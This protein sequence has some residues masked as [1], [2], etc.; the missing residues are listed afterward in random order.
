[1]TKP[2]VL[3]LATFVCATSAAAQ[4]PTLSPAL[5]R[6]RV[7]REWQVKAK[8]MR[9]ILQPLMRKHG[10]DL[11]V[12]MSRENAPDPAI[13]LFGGN[14]ITGRYGHRNAF[15]LR[16][17]GD[18]QPLETHVI[19]THSGNHSPGFHRRPRSVVAPRPPDGVVV[20]HSPARSAL[21]PHTD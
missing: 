21:E 19:G 16:D 11:W 18:G 20:V 15:L 6:H 10:I 14:G 8:K 7:E 2:V 1:M 3:A 12:I 17:P 13:E 5:I 9:T 4:P